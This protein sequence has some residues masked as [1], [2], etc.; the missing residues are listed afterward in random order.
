MQLFSS[1]Q[2]LPFAPDKGNKAFTLKDQMSSLKKI[3]IPDAINQVRSLKCDFILYVYV[4]Q[5]CTVSCD[6]L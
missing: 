2:D 4:I 5:P 3:N 6:I 1:L